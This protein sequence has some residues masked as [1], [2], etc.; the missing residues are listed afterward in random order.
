[1]VDFFHFG[2]YTEFEIHELV[3]HELWAHTEKPPGGR[4]LPAVGFVHTFEH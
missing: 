2:V 1:M 3:V 4:P